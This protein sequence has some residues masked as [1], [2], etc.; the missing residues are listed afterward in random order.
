MVYSSTKSALQ[1]LIMVAT[2]LSTERDTTRLLEEIL[3]HAKRLTNADAGTI[4][5]VHDEQLKFEMLLN[6]TLGLEMGGSTGKPI[7]FD[8]IPIFIDG[9]TN[10]SALVAVAAAT[11]HVINIDNVYDEIHYNLNA[12]RRMDERTGYRTQSVL[13]I[14]MLNH[15]GDLNGVLQLI[16]AQ[17]GH[18]VVPFN[19]EAVSLITS[20]ASLAAVALTN[21]A[22]IDGM[23]QLFKSLAELIAKAI[24]EK[25]PYT[26]GHC[27][28]VPE[29]TMMLADAVNAVN[30]GEFAE[31]RLTDVD[32]HALSIAGW[33][34]DCGKI[35][36]PEYVM[37]KSTKLSTIFDRIEMVVTRLELAIRDLQLAIATEGRDNPEQVE[38]WQTQIAEIKDMQ[39]Y[40]RATNMGG[41]FM[42]PESQQRVADFAQRY[43]VWIEDKEQPILTDNEVYNLQIAR[44]TLTKE[45]RQ[46]INRHMDVTLAMLEA[47]PFPKHLKPVPEYAGGH[48]EKLDGTGYPRGL[49]K[50]QMSPPA[51]MMAIADIF[52]ALTA[53][54]R[55]YKP[56]KPLSE[57][58]KIMC[59]MCK[60]L[61]IDTDLFEVFLKEGVF[62]RYAQQFLA[63]EQ[64]DV[65]DIE[66]F[67]TM[68]GRG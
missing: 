41:E 45:E 51:R 40:L 25:S 29:L 60:D 49:T 26:G 17:N 9:E 36:T 59:F 22:L 11:K 68:I 54:D 61:H 20:L 35:A 13:T 30:Y 16:N 64:C 62:T 39:S 31:F 55:P 14:P 27:R 6:D 3:L 19:D 8:H 67:L 21:R 48:H 53:S 5:S 57:C 46:I 65:E 32:R 12:A 38:H 44:G 58:L 42:S 43:Q 47:L 24:D 66:H 23:E 28:R 7:P 10:E 33:L 15:E 2:H 63:A 37:D 1:T 56:A 52:E 4:Y 18:T 50:E 34:H